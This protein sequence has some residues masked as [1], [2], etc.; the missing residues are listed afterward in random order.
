MITWEESQPSAEAWDAA[1]LASDDYNV[2]QSFAWGEYKRTAGWSPGRL[3]ARNGDGEIVGMVQILT[4]R[5]PAD[6]LFGWSPGGPVAEFPAQ[7]ELEPLIETLAKHLA[8]SRTRWCVRFDNYAPRTSERVSAFGKFLNRASIQIN[9][10]FSVCFDLNEPAES[11]IQ[12]L[13]SKHHKRNLA[14]ALSANIDWQ[15]GNDPAMVST[16]SQLYKTMLREKSLRIERI[17]D[18]DISSL[19]QA[20]KHR[21]VILTGFFEGRPVASC[22]SLAFGRKAMFI[23][24]ATSNDGRRVRASYSMIHRLL[25]HLQ[26]EGVTEFDFGGIDPNSRAAAGVNRFKQGF[27]GTIVQRTGEWESASSPPLRWLLNLSLIRRKLGQ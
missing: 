7:G 23:M 10:S 27:G 25:Q 26:S 21:A 19:C 17:S 3:W 6:I 11:L 18:S 4:K 24:G 15:L 1:L 16:L 8:A 13:A 22:L 2:Y 12:R 9:S 14:K 20:S 5:L